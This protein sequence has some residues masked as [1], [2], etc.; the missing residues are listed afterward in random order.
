MMRWWHAGRGIW[1]RLRALGRAAFVLRVPLLTAVI[2]V[3][4]LGTDQMR[5]VIA[6]MIAIRKA[7][8]S[9]PK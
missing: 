4:V 6:V 1:R 7:M 3:A 9:A 8:P 2:G 5:E